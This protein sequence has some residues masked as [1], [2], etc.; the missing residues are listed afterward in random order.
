MSLLLTAHSLRNRLCKYACP[1]HES[2]DNN[3]TLG[4]VINI[5]FSCPVSL[6]TSL[7]KRGRGQPGCVLIG[8]FIL[9]VSTHHTQQAVQQYDLAVH[10]NYIGVLRKLLILF[11]FTYRLLTKHAQ[12]GCKPSN[13]VSIHVCTGEF[14]GPARRP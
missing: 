7:D 10:I 1:H 4:M 11:L 13:H 2:W 9:Y 14:P 12:S 3:N 6:H 8:H 5:D